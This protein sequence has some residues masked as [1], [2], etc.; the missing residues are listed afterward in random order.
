MKKIKSVAERTAEREKL[1]DIKD[2]IN[3]A[4]TVKG[5]KAE[6]QRLAELVEKHINS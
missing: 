5:L 1:I 2:K 4:D 6:V 3:K